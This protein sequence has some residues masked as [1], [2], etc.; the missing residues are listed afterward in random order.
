M[1]NPGKK[2]AYTGQYKKAIEMS[3]L[4][5]FNEAG[6]PRA[7]VTQDVASII[8][9]MNQLGI[10]FERWEANAALPYDAEQEE[11]LAAYQDSISKLNETYGFKFVDVSVLRPDH[12]KKEELR[13]QFNTE[14][15]HEDFEIRF[16]VEGCGLF[17]FHFDDKVYLL[18]CEKG[19]LISVPA[20][21]DHWFDMG[22]SPDF[23][24]IRF[25]PT[26]DGWV[27]EKTGSDIASRLPDLDA[28]L[29]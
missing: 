24:L 1:L 29:A 7:A 17:Y 11:I 6:Q 21:T 25:F 12:P 8:A 14:H 22:S 19:D 15:T 10:Q 27:A 9:Q 4:Q 2:Q 3:A 26:Q 20:K 16:F 5:V 18:L 28:F 23:K 13:R